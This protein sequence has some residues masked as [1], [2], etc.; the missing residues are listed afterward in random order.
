VFRPAGVF[1]VSGER[2][3][4]VGITAAGIG[5][6]T[7]DDEYAIGVAFVNE[8]VAVGASLAPCGAIALSEHGAAVVLNEHSLAFEHHEKFVLAIVPVAL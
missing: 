8:M 4:D 3:I 2:Q 6:S 1:T 5:A 7:D